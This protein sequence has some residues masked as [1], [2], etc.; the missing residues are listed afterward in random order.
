MSSYYSRSVRVCAFVMTIAGFAAPVSAADSTTVKVAFWNVMSGKG[1]DALTGHPKP[2]VNTSNCTDATQ[3]MNAWGVGAM[4]AVLTQALSDPSVVAL[5]LAEAWST[6]CGSPEH[7]RQALGWKMQTG[8]QNGV[9]LVSRY[10]LA[11]GTTPQWQQL[12]TTQNLTPSDTMWVL[13]AQV[14]TDAACTASIPVYVAH[15]YGTGTYSQST[16]DRQAQQTVAFTGASSGQPHVLVGD[17]NTFEGTS[18]ACS[19]NPNNSSLTY[20]RSAGYVDG[21]V[22]LHSADPGYTGMANRAGCGVPEGNTWKRIDYAWTPSAFPPTDIQRFATTTPGDA[23]PSDHYGIIVTLP[24]PGAQAPTPPPPA[25]TPA[26]A[27]PG[28]IVL[29]AKNATTIAGAWVR[30][31]DATAAGGVRLANPDAGA[32]KLASASTS[33][34][35]YFEL[36]FMAAPGQAYRLWI[37]GKAEND[38]WANDSVFVQFSGSL[39][40]K[41]ASAFRIGTT[42]ATIVN[43]EDASGAGLSGWGWQDN[44][45]GANVLGPAIYFDGTPQT[46]RVQVREDGLSIDQILLSPVTYATAAPG[47]GKDDTTILQQNSGNGGTTPASPGPTTPAPPPAPAPQPAPGS[48]PSRVSSGVY[49]AV[50]DRK[51]YAKPSLP[52]LGGAGSTVLDPV[53]QSTITRITD[54]M[55]RPGAA[56][57]SYRTPSSPHQNIW[58]V[59]DSYFYITGSGGVGPIPYAFDQATGTARRLQP[60]ASGDGGL[61]LNFYIEPQ[62]SYVADSI[63]Y[64]S[65]NGSGSNLHTIDQYDFSTGTYTRLLDLE[66]VVGGLS[67]TY[68]G[69]IGSSGGSNERILAFF[70][71]A[72]QDLHRYVVVFDKANP[73]NRQLLDSQASTINGQHSPITLSFNL[74]HAAIDRSGRYVML[75]ST[76]VD[77]AAPRSAAQEYLWDLQTGSVT[78][79]G[80]SALPYGHDA[81]GYG[82]LVNKDCC[83]ATE[84]DAGQWEFR[85]LSAPL[86]TRDLIPTV[87]QPKEIYLSD[88]TTWNNAR[89]DRQMPVIS[90]LYRF[91]LEGSAWR[92]WDDEIIAIQTDAPGVDPTVWRFAHHRS[93]VTYDGDASRLAFWY[94]PHPNVS[95]DG[96]W[97]LFTS[98]WEKSLGTGPTTPPPPPPPAPPAVAPV[99]ITTAALPNGQATVAY[100]A[101]LQA[102]GG[103]GAFAWTITAGALPAGLTLDA[104]TGTIAGTPSAAGTYTFTVTVADASNTANRAAAAYT[105]TIA[106]ASPAPSPVGPVHIT[107]PRT[108][109]QAALGQPY[110]YVIPV[111]NV[112][113]IAKWSVAG[114]SLPPGM[115]LTAS[116]GTVSGTPTTRGTFNFNARVT[117]SAGNDTLTLTLV[118]K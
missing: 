78:E 88:H 21:W 79:L 17:F 47:A 95:Q 40:S 57:Y 93:D 15:W 114:G 94:Q 54:N 18:P 104:V 55:T 7:I 66:T 105:V 65:Y 27:T 12:D 109:P 1:V 108:L 3:P 46:L 113:G 80:V 8:E 62:F 99:A 45:Y 111:E 23:S 97:V 58:S 118:V 67:G 89:A 28:D 84:W 38:S 77:Q 81:F 48:G 72:S 26:P 43:I 56:D 73:Q 86:A 49:T 59:N 87:L 29:Y 36:P 53:F 4:Q 52:V 30:V 37:R 31:N 70:G 44:G 24:N 16:Y 25:P 106:A 85:A 22:R 82:T 115:T 32:P 13:R 14:C 90:G 42:A 19:Q 83:T 110:S 60:S 35:S 33:P 71:G 20:L 117:D 69:G 102:S 34:A 92:A 103:S 63:I 11:A 10:G 51:A 39:D 6:V 68:I 112:H 100:S 107:S 9:A 91:G 76:S 75:Y 64:G 98:N 101:A 5:G 61:V 50:I 96:R 116:T 74:H 41:N 2:F